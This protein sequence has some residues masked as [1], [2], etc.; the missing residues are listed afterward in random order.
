MTLKIVELSPFPENCNPFHHD[1]SHMGTPIGKDLMLMHSNHN[2]EECKYLI[3]VNT[4]TGKRFR[5]ELDESCGEKVAMNMMLERA[6][7]ERDALVCADTPRKT[8][9]QVLAEAEG[10]STR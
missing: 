9:A 8:F 3:F 5:L 6:L 10:R 2:T 4:K 7:R 1:L